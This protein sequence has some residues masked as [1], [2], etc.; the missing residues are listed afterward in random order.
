MV[1]VPGSLGCSLRRMRAPYITSYVVFRGGFPRG[2]FFLTFNAFSRA[3]SSRIS[4]SNSSFF[5]SPPSL[6]FLFSVTTHHHP[7]SSLSVLPNDYPFFHHLKIFSED[8]QKELFLS[9]LIGMIYSNFSNESGI[10]NLYN[11]H[12][13]LSILLWF[14]L[15]FFSF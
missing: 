11:N 13:T 15:L 8:L 5:S 3:P 2:V 10:F 1:H 7:V 6:M 12:I 14:F 4:I 9:R